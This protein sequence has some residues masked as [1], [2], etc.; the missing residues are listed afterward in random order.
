MPKR[1]LN[2]QLDEVIEDLLGGRP[3]AT[4]DPG[5]TSLVAIARELVDLP[6]ENFKARLKSELERKLSMSSQTQ[7]A[8]VAV[9]QTAIPRLR[10]KN[11]AA[12]IEFYKQAFGAVDRGAMKDPSGKIMH[13]ELKIGDSVVIS[14][15]PFDRLFT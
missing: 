1:S 7:A 2:H 14:A 15:R 4:S 6:R 3:A 10:I 12:A 9:R 8:P 11:A 5:L 13:A